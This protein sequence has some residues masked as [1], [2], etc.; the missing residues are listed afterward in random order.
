MLGVWPA[1]L[2]GGGSFAVSQFLV[3]NYSGPLLVDVVSSLVS[4]AALTAFLR[5]WQPARIEHGAIAATSSAAATVAPEAARRR[6]EPGVALRAWAPWVILAVF[7]FVAC[8]R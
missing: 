6:H 5:I 3:S 7:V 1:I 4:I 8:R 2:V